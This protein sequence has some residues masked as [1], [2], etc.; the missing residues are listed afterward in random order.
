MIS[1]LHIAPCG[2]NCSLCL[3]FQREKNKCSGCNAKDGSKVNHCNVCKI[4]N[5]TEHS[6]AKT[7]YCYS[8]GKFPCKRMKQLDKRYRTK[9][10]M[11]MIKNLRTIEAHGIK[12]FAE[13]ETKK[14]TCRKC[15]SLLCVHRDSCQHCGSTNKVLARE[16][17]KLNKT[18]I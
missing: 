16:L 11:S 4:K 13:M 14:W 12:S 15:G 1:A 3:A 5:C 9:Y 8:C 2:M 7:E 10:G 17:I 6:N 18:K